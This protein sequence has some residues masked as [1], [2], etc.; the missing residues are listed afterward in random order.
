MVEED[1]ISKL[2]IAKY[3]ANS[4]VKD[5]YLGVKR[6]G[7][8][9]CRGWIDPEKRDTT[10]VTNVVAGVGLGLLTTI[11]GMEGYLDRV[12]ELFELSEY[13]NLPGFLS[14][15]VG[16]GGTVI[17]IFTSPIVD[18]LRSKREEATEELYK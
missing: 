2:Q 4:F 15:C 17:P 3:M 6:W 10:I 1:S 5:T 16:V 7:R 13:T 14:L 18:R 11:A 9:Y 8:D 12:Y